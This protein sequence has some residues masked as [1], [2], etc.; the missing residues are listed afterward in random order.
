MVV[1]F[2]GAVVLSGVLV[3]WL[4]SLVSFLYKAGTK[5]GGSKIDIV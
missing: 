2:G 4:A 3:A 5:I 1:L